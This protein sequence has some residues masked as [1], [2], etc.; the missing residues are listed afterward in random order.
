[1][2][3]AIPGIR[4]IMITRIMTG[5]TSGVWHLEGQIWPVPAYATAKGGVKMLTKALA[6][7]TVE[8]I[9]SLSV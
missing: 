4:T 1:M 5:E 9:V 2:T 3:T 8:N 6:V 7:K